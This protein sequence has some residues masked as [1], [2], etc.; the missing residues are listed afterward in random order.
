MTGAMY[1]LTPNTVSTN[2]D[3]ATADA[4]DPHTLTVLLAQDIPAS[5]WKDAQRLE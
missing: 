4:A 3:A 1:R 5:M 2:L